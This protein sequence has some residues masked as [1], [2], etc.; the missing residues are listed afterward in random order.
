MVL[1]FVSYSLTVYSICSD[2]L[3]TKPLLNDQEGLESANESSLTTDSNN[4]VIFST[5]NSEKADVKHW[6]RKL[7]NCLHL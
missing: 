1:A 3:N 4:A 2:Y 6:L 7:L 5:I